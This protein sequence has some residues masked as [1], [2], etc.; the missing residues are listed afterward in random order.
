MP[1]FLVDTIFPLFNAVEA[2]V[3]PAFVA[4]RATFVFVVKVFPI[5]TFTV[6]P[7]APTKTAVESAV[8]FV[9]V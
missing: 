8:P 4:I 1:E 2:L 7:F 9:T 5:S 6:E 3:P